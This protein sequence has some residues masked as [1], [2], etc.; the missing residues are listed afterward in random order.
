MVYSRLG[1]FMIYSETLHPCCE[2][3]MCLT[4]ILIL[5]FVNFKNDFHISKSPLRK[6]YKTFKMN[7]SFDIVTLC[8]LGNF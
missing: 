7:E 2:F 5:N 4:A 6:I 3:M 8:M 1:S